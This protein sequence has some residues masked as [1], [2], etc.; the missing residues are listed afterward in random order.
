MNCLRHEL[1]CT[2]LRATYDMTCRPDIVSLVLSPSVFCQFSLDPNTAATN[3][4][5]SENNR[6]ATLVKEKQP[7]PDDPERFS[8]W[9]QVLCAEGVTGRCYWEVKCNGWVT[10][11]VAYRGAGKNM[12][13]YDCC[14][15]RT[16]QSWSLLCSA[17]G[18]TAWHFSKPTK[19]T[20]TP[21]SGSYSVGVYVDWSA[22]TVS[23][24]CLPSL[25]SRTRV[26]LHT[27]HSTFR[28]PLYPAFGFERVCDFGTDSRFLKASIHLSQISED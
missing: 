15:G 1:H 11:G 22:G 5:L 7:Y 25:I 8:N 23:F 13:E 10:V 2:L 27:F 3:L 19:I 9:T 12:D 28:E 14:L 18:Y 26:H 24:Y 17:Q 4:L 16:A 20:Y 6:H 21:P